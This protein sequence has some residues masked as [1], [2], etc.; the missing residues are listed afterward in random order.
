MSNDRRIEERITKWLVSTAPRTLPDRV[1]ADTFERTRPME[2]ASGLGRGWLD[3]LRLR[4]IVLVSATVA[5]V[6]ITASIGFEPN[7]TVPV[8]APLNPTVS[9]VWTVNDDV[10]VTIERNLNDSR[11]HYW[12]AVTFD[13]IGLRG[14]GMSSTNTKML[15]PG[16]RTLEGMAE[17][18]DATG[19]HRVTFTVRPGTFDQPTVLSPATPIQI[20][21]RVRLTTVG[22][23]GYFVKLDRLDGDVYTVTALVADRGNAP[24]MLNRSALRAAGADYP[25]EVVAL[26]T[27][28]V[29]QM[30]GPNLNRLRDEVVRTAKS[31]APIDLAER[32]VEVLRSPR[33]SYDVDVRD[34]ECGAMSAP[35]CFAMSRRGYCLHYAMTMAVVLRDLGVPAR[36]VQGFAPGMRDQQSGTEVIRNSDA[37]AWV[38]VYFPGYEW[39]AFDPTAAGLPQQLPAKLPPG[40]PAT[41]FTSLSPTG[42]STR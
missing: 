1:L 3:G 34:I 39:V 27:A 25:P 35:E 24:G 11:D 8:A 26:Y 6:L 16:V 28:D 14:L 42:S 9:Q 41:S 4:P 36:V 10:A 33:Y 40:S 31:T 20:D 30:F 13:Q 17:D 21:R 22:E 15:S 5:I 23:D 12:R 29:A 38:E 7:E 37:F 2:Q 18:V 19:L 32:L